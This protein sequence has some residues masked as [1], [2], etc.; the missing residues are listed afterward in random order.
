MR[1][2]RLPYYVPVVARATSMDP[3]P[4]TW[5]T[6]LQMQNLSTSYAASVS[7]AFYWAVGTPSAGQLAA[8]YTATIPAGG[9][10]GW[11]LPSGDI[12]SVPAGFRGSLVVSSD[13]P[14]AV[15]ANAEDTTGPVRKGTVRAIETPSTTLRFPQVQYQFWGWNSYVVLQNTSGSNATATIHYYN[16][17]GGE[18]AGAAQTQT[19]PAYSSWISHQRSNP[20]LPYFWA[21]SAVVT[22]N[23]ALAGVATLYENMSDSAS[24]DFTHYGALTEASPTVYVP[25]IVRYY[26]GYNSGLAI[27]NAGSA[28]TTVSIQYKFAGHT[29]YQTISGLQPSA[30]ALLFLPDVPELNP[31]DGLHEYYRSGSAIVTASQPLVAIANERYDGSDPLFQGFSV[32]YDAF[33]AGTGSTAIGFSQ[34]TSR[35]WGYCGGVQVQNVG[36]STTDV[37]ATFSAP[38]VHDVITTATVLAG[39]QVQWFAPQTVGYE[40]WDWNGSV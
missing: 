35:F 11:H 12:P 15:N 3:L 14:L 28:S 21:G 34:V 36:G 8:T 13:Q 26:Y 39:A 31:V 17:T 22:S 5:G 27:Q 33:A 30:S 32:T 16:T 40:K 37:T 29:Y 4:G 24:S 20:N 19:I 6:G 10:Q 1:F 9:S 7:L 38:G 25:R 2:D 23:A 18:V